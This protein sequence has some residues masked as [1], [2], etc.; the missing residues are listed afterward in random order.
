LDPFSGV[1][2]QICTCPSHHTQRNKQRQPHCDTPCTHRFSTRWQQRLGAIPTLAT[3][4][5]QARHSTC[6]NFSNAH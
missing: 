4:C 3:A 5:A 2:A 6:G 1:A